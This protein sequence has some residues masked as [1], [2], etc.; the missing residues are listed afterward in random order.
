PAHPP[1]RAEPR[2]RDLAGRAAADHGRRTDRDGDDGREALRRSRDAAP[3]PRSRAAGPT[4]TRLRLAAAGAALAG[5]L[6]ATGCGGGG[7]SSTLDILFV[8]SRGSGS[9]A[10]WGMNADGSRQQRLT[11]GKGSA[12]SISGSFHEVDPAW[13][14]NGRLIAF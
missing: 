7:G 8:S 14:P 2:G 1:D 4:L 3:L 5:C 13:S 6:V 11:Q 9:Y 10:I 12:S